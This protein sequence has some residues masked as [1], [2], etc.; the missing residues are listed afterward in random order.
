MRQLQ[1]INR[2]SFPHDSSSRCG[3]GLPVDD[4]D[5][6][7]DDAGVIDVDEVDDDAV[8]EDDARG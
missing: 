2:D 7:E 6:A 3:G 8:V 4:A 5:G 1:A